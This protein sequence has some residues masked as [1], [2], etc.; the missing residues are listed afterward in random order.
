MHCT[1]STAATTAAASGDCDMQDQQDVVTQ[2]AEMRARMNEV[3]A[4]IV[5]HEKIHADDPM[6]LL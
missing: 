3:Y 2:L 5:N 1:S 6:S 4:W